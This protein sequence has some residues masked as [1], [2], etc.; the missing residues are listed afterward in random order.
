MAARYG[1]LLQLH[2]AKAKLVF[3]IGTLESRLLEQHGRDE[4]WPDLAAQSNWLRT[5]GAIAA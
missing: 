3:V 5:L 1:A 2:V 4:A